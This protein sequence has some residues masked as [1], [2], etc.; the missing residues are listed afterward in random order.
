[1]F[2][3][4]ETMCSNGVYGSLE[5]VSGE[6]RARRW[7]SVIMTQKNDVNVNSTGVLGIN[8]QNGENN[9]SYTVNRRFLGRSTVVRDG[10][11]GWF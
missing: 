7:L 3:P 8:G 6:G 1:M 5:G 2:T 10:Q 9:R 4:L 11:K